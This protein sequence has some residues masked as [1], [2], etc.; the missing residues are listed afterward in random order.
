MISAIV[1]PG[2]CL[3]RYRPQGV[4]HK[5]AKITPIQ[6]MLRFGQISFKKMCAG[7]SG[8]ATFGRLLH[9]DIS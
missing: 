5:V 9:C 3:Q 6:G 1:V 2:A 4:M 7:A 8:G